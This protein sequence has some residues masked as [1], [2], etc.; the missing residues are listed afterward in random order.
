MR[1]RL[2]G[3]VEL[4][5][6]AGRVDLGGPRQRCVFTVLAM[7]PRQTVPMET[8]I[9][10]VW[11]DQVPRNVRTVLYTYV[12]RLRSLLAEATDGA[13]AG[14]SLLRRRAGGYQLELAPDEIDLHRSRQLV[15]QARA[16]A[17]TGD[18]AARRRAVELLRSA[19]E[20]WSGPPLT[21]I[22][23]DWAERVRTGLEHERLALLTE[24]FE[25]ELRLGEHEQVI[26]PLSETL[27]AY[28]LTE[29]LAAQ[30]MVALHRAGRH[31]EALT[32]YGDL[33]RRMVDE[34]GDE[35]GT[36]LRRLHERVLRRDPELLPPPP[37][38]AP[39][40]PAPMAQPFEPAP[41]G[42]D[43]LGSAPEPAGAPFAALCQLPPDIWHFVGR[44]Q[45]T[46]ELVAGLDPDPE[47]TAVGVVAINGAPGVGKSALAVHVAHQLRDRFPDGQWFIQLGGVTDPAKPADVIEELLI[48]SGL[49]PA[50]VP[51][52]LPQRTATLRA[53]LADRRVLVVLDDAASAAQLR[54]L[55]PGTGSAA[56]VVT[57]RRRLG[58]LPDAAHV[59]LDPLDHAAALT[60]LGKLAGAG[61]VA[62]EPDAAAEICAACARS[63]LA[64]QI[65]A[66]RL[67]A[68][69]EWRL[70]R[71]AAR[72]REPG[73]RLDELSVGDLAVRPELVQTHLSLD[74]RARGALGRLAPLGTRHFSASTAAALT[75]V[76]DGDLLVEELVAAALLDPVDSDATAEPRYR[77]SEL[78][79]AY[80][81]ELDEQPAG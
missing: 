61:R 32:V 26:G 58:G 51:A 15:T 19:G 66:A 37:L 39:S 45:L 78:V 76:R 80:A 71:F 44:E 57:G 40:P 35:P 9:E 5:S 63:P 52:G 46:K 74:T 4:G 10:R 70:E 25:A 7:T 12:S 14:Q 81:A 68:H 30:L 79:A 6:S 75:G 23:G 41:A 69:P 77:L 60:L 59:R 2:L 36:E 62:A 20:L 54:P 28:P 49:A 56:V 31:A 17:G 29:S 27:A 11:G 53:R 38:A 22:S 1:V 72:L 42:A 65:A 8:L 67:S 43:E 24:R 48:A 34:L 3:S 64:L 50:A 47:R 18:P 16:A 21:G 13:A 73:R 33:R 55:L